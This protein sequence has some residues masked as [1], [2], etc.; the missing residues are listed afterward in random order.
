M[1]VMVM[2]NPVSG[3]GKSCRHAGAIAE[4]LI[5]IPCDVELVQTQT[6][7]PELW[8]APKLQC[9]PDAI[10]VV[11]G[12]GTLRQIASVVKET[13][14]PVYHSACGTENLFAKS[15]ALDAHPDAV[16]RAIIQNTTKK[17]HMIL[18]IFLE[19]CFVLDY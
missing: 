17:Y 15:M 10:V 11:G 12:D 2:Y 6:I 16:V 1:R 3:R 4:R 19:E 8:L 9:N 7:S 14:I 18:C 5:Q 13:N